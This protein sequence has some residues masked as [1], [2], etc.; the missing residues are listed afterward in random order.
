MGLLLLILLIIL[1]IVAI[2]GG[3][4]VSHALFWILI[5]AAIVAVVMWAMDRGPR[6]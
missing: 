4:F 6:P 3:I 2:P 1:L 5:I